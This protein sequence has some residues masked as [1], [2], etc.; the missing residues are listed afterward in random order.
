MQVA[1]VGEAEMGAEIRGGMIP[2]HSTRESHRPRGGSGRRSVLLE[3]DH[4]MIQTTQVMMVETGM[5]TTPRTT[6][7]NPTSLGWAT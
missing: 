7:K 1:G 2:Q 6:Q 3:G 4:Q 5:G